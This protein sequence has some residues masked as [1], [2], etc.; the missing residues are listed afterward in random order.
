[1]L[2][3]FDGRE[4]R[5]A[6]EDGRVLTGTAESFP[7]GYGLQEFGVEEEG[8]TMEDTVVFLSEIRD[9][10]L[11]PD[12]EIRAEQPEQYDVL[13]DSLL[14]GPY[15]IADI[16]PEQVPRD[17][18]GQYFAVDRYFREPSRLSALYRRFAEILLRVNCWYDMTVSFD[19]CVSWEKNPEPE[20]FARRVSQLSESGFFRALFPAQSFMIELDSG[21]TWMTVYGEDEGLLEKIEKLVTADGLFLWSPNRE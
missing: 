12:R 10:Q 19:G 5:I 8:V 20:G 13:V 2:S 18:P 17:A 15:R 7:A 14:N 1:M 21:D 3:R 4:V 6:T 9:I 11:L 16:L